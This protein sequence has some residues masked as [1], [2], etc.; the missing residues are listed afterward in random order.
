MLIDSH[1][2]LTMPQYHDDREE[3]IQRA[4]EAGLVHIITVGTDIADCCKAVNLAEA[5]ETVSATVGIHPH[6]VKAINNGTYDHLKDLAAH[7]KVVAIGE[8]G[9]D[10]YRNLS[11]QAIQRHHFRQ[12][13]QL[14]WEVSLPVV[15]HDRDAHQDVVTILCEE[16]AVTVGGVIHCFSGDW[17]MAKRCLDMGFYISIPGTITFK[18]NDGYY[19]IIRKIPL[20]RLLVETD[21]PFLAPKPF[22]GKRNEPAYVHFVSEKAAQIRGIDPAELGAAITRNAIELFRL[23][24]NL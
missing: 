22:R 8:I 4:H 16:N 24:L 3:V 1:A 7:E 5:H 14:A 15:I 23:P 19:D 6:D 9:L 10:F 2:H 13:L 11:P 17:D 12:Q 20:E 21:C 18:P